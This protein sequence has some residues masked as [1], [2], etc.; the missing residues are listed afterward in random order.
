MKYDFR[1]YHKKYLKSEKN[2]NLEPVKVVLLHKQFR[3][4][5]NVIGIKS[6]I[7]TFKDRATDNF[8]QPSSYEKTWAI[9]SRFDWECGN[10]GFHYIGLYTLLCDFLRRAVYGRVETNPIREP[11]KEVCALNRAKNGHGV[12]KQ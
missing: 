8:H 4:Y 12:C 2:Q 1:I 6:K 3:L 9:F 10:N 7:T 11:Q 5:T